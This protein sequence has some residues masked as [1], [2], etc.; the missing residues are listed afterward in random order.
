M[1]ACHA[2]VA[3]FCLACIFSLAT[4]PLPVISQDSKPDGASTEKTP[5]AGVNGVGS[6]KCIYC[7]PPE[8]SEEARDA[9]FQGTVL[10]D[11]AIT[12]EGKATNVIVIK[13]PGKGLEQKAIEAVKSWRFKPALDKEGNPIQVRVAVE[14]TFH[15][16][17]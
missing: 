15:L 10:L 4:A 5:R 1:N 7:P 9:K 13:G 8:Y 12:T 14:V 11:V 3:V 16:H 2:R 6:P 17:K